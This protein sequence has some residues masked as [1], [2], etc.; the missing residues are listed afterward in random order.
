MCTPHTPNIES[1]SCTFFLLRRLFL[2]WIMMKGAAI[3]HRNSICNCYFSPLNRVN[4]RWQEDDLAGEKSR[5]IKLNIGFETCSRDISL[6]LYVKKKLEI[7][8][9]ECNGIKKIAFF[10]FY[11]ILFDDARFSARK[12]NF[13]RATKI[14]S[15][16]FSSTQK[17][18]SPILIL[19]I[20][21]RW[22]YIFF[23]TGSNLYFNCNESISTTVMKSTF[24]DMEKVKQSQSERKKNM[25]WAYFSWTYTS[26]FFRSWFRL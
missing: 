24:E 6:Y 25:I 26:I 11:S 12:E 14:D 4:N 20:S 13:C 19:I 18:L 5:K 9:V 21:V 22:I 10:L 2:L 1:L 8:D 3:T 7:V 23:S 15:K 17:N 16:L